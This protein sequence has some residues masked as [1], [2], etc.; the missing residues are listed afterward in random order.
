[1]WA[2]CNEEENGKYEF[3]REDGNTNAHWKPQRH[4]PTLLAITIRDGITKYHMSFITMYSDTAQSA[5][6]WVL[7]LTHV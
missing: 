1:M 7:A 6:T 5:I 3:N 4:C 2:G